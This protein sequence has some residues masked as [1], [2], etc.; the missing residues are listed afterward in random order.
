[1]ANRF[2]TSA[3][4]T[5]AQPERTAIVLLQ[6][7][8]P[9]APEPKAVRTYLKQFLSDPRVVEIPKLVWSLILNGIILNV[10]PKKSAAKYASVWTDEGSPLAVHTIRQTKLLRGYLGERGH[11]VEVVYA[12]RYGNPS[13]ASVLNELREKN[14]TRLLC[15]PM[16]PQYAGATTATALDEVFRELSNYLTKP[17][18]FL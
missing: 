14:V 10:R 16:Y 7:G 8:T 15:L 18:Q 9:D 12:M 1:M 2:T 5:H 17:H 11:D 6:L 13:I 3:S 4:F